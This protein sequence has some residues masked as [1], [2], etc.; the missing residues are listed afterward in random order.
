MRKVAMHIKNKDIWIIGGGGHSKVIIAGCQSSQIAVNGLF[1]DN[2]DIWGT[3]LWDIKISPLPGDEWWINQC[4]FLAIGKNKV[5]QDLSKKISPKKWGTIVHPTAIVHPSAFI[6]DGCYVGAYAVI[7]PDVHIGK[8]VIVN[9][10]AIIEHDVKIESFC[11]IA[12][13]TVLAGGSSVGEGTLIGVGS[14]VIPERVIGNWSVIG[15][16]AVVVKNIPSHSV[17]VGVPCKII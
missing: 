2:Q 14:S 6:D 10:G 5:R 12:P 16:G 8:H 4:G 7:Q 17:A 15:A 13:R 1:D 9:T 3:F 11:H